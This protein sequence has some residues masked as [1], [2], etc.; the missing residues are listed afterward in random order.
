MSRQLFRAR[1]AA[2]ALIVASLVCAAAAVQ[3]DERLSPNA[4]ARLAQSMNR[5]A[6]PAGIQEFRPADL[7]AARIALTTQDAGQADETESEFIV[8]RSGDSFM[9][10]RGAIPP[11]AVA[12]LAEVLSGAAPVMGLQ[13]CRGNATT[14]Q[15]QPAGYL[16]V[17]ISL[18]IQGRRPLRL[19]S[20]S[21]CTHRLPWNLTDGQRLAAMTRPEA[22][23]AIMA[24]ANSACGGCI[25]AAGDDMPTA[26][27]SEAPSDFDNHYARL[28]S[29]WR[30]LGD[31]HGATEIKLMTFHLTEALEWMDRA[32]FESRLKKTVQQEASGVAALARD[33]LRMLAAERWGYIDKSGRFILPRRF[34]KAE[35]FDA[36]QAL[37]RIDGLWQLVDR[38]GR[39]VTEART[40]EPSYQAVRLQ[41]AERAGKWGFATADGKLV[42]PAVFDAVAPF[43]QGLAAVQLA[44]KW[45]YLDEA[46]HAAIAPRFEAA[47]DFSEGL[48]A[49][50]LDG[51]WGYVDRQ[52]GVVIHPRFLEA[53]DFGNGLAPVR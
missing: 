40:G 53:G 19:R 25:A 30:R 8:W 2:R 31:R 14:A 5:D 32:R 42:I 1:H 12:T 22:G 34:E 37:V 26:A 21:Q 48:A 35:R 43:Q 7:I 10:E 46:G 11:Q 16:R 24:L 23:K 50:K 15:A 29:D 49:V 39:A 17:D 41:P 51:L 20:E 44:G 28:A 9:S 13:H 38:R 18:L 27:A 33:M 52:G 3:A 4:F 45:G 6:V 36:G 47:R